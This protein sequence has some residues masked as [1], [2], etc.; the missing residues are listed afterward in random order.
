MSGGLNVVIISAEHTL[1][2][3]LAIFRIYSFRHGV[4]LVAIALKRLLHHAYAALGE[5][6]SLQRSVCL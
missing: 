3:C 4:E 2:V 1:V 6:A 5:D